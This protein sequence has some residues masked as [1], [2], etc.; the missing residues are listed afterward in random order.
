[1]KT[2]LKE[3]WFKILIVIIFIAIV[4]GASYWYRIGFKL[5][6]PTA[7]NSSQEIATGNGQLTN[8]E[9]SEI[10][11]SIVKLICFPADKN[12]WRVYGSGIYISENSITGNNPSEEGFE[13]IKGYVLTNGHVAELKKTLNACDVTL[14]SRNWLGYFVYNKKTHFLNE[15]ID[16]VLMKIEQAFTGGKVE[17][18][19]FVSWDTLKSYLLKYYPT[20]P[21]TSIIGVKVYVFGYPGS[22]FEYATG[23]EYDEPE[24]L[25]RNLIVFDGLISGKDS[26][27]D[28]YTTAKIDAG[29]SGGLAVAKINGEICIVGIPTWISSGDYENIGI[30]Q[31]F[32][33]IRRALTTPPL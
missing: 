15:N 7:V 23:P 5:P 31:S 33:K 3:N 12:A 22:A 28:F 6:L 8:K 25:E 13:Y 10:S 19:P 14:H 21:D 26:N 1:M 32:E 16:V 30:I 18:K 29:V 2:W 27:G 24:L 11:K 9:I 17:W 20:C 4:G